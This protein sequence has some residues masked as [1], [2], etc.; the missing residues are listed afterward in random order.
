LTSFLGSTGRFTAVLL[1]GIVGSFSCL[2]GAIYSLSPTEQLYI[3]LSNNLVLNGGSILHG[4]VGVTT[5][6]NIPNGSIASYVQFPGTASFSGAV[7]CTSCTGKI[8]GGTVANDTNVSNAI[9]Q[10]N[11]LI[12][13]LQSTVGINVG[14]VTNGATFTTGVYDA[15][16]LSINTAAGITFDAQGNPNNQF[17]LVFPSA[18]IAG[19]ATINLINGAQPDNVILLYTGTNNLNWSSSGSRA[20]Y[21]EAQRTP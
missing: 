13:T 4:D 11:S 18:N 9:S 20:F 21:W 12:T 16:S 7:S 15:T 19:S 3:T 1:L 14:A 10:Y 8:A 2:R 6:V 17:V 5:N